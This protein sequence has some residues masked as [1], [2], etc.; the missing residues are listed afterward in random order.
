M[1]KLLLLILVTILASLM[2]GC[3]TPGL[4][5]AATA[6]D[7]SKESVAVMSLNM[8]N[9]IKP[10]YTLKTGSFAVVKQGTTTPIVVGSGEQFAD[11]EDIL[12]N[13]KLAPGRYN[14]IRIAGRTALGLITGT[15]V[16]EMTGAFD[17][18]PNSV[19]Y[20]GHLKLVNKERTNPDDQASGGVIPLLDQAVSGFASGT[21]DVV[22]QD[23]YERDSQL[24]KETFP[25][26]KNTVI[27]RAPIMQISI[28]RAFSSKASPVQ[29]MLKT[30]F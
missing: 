7:L 19:V 21:L 12:I 9:E 4:D 28:P 25:A 11:N 23:R 2:S 10:S 17:V 30:D 5:R 26:L 22:L 24:L 27:V 20:L 1:R 3:A 29:L 6:L 15:L 8:R 14:L 18:A 16:Y 13:V